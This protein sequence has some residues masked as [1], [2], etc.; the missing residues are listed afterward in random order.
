MQVDC[1]SSSSCDTGSESVTLGVL[2]HTVH[3]S[4]NWRQQQNI[5][6][7]LGRFVLPRRPQPIVLRVSHA[8]FVLMQLP[9]HIAC[10]CPRWRVYE[11][12]AGGSA[13][14]MVNL[15]WVEAHAPATRLQLGWHAPCVLQR[16]VCRCGIC[17]LYQ[18]R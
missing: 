13:L 4:V 14:P 16:D 17:L 3:L 10:R 12:V 8:F 6:L 15:A 2:Q 18:R 5:L 9:A 7:V 11:L 1:K